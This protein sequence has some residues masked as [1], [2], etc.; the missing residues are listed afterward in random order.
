MLSIMAELVYEHDEMMYDQGDLSSTT[1]D[2][3]AQ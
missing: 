1:K 3:F 2:S